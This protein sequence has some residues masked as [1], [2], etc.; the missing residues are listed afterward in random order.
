MRKY[1]FASITV[2]LYIVGLLI[3][4]PR[5]EISYAATGA[6]GVCTGNPGTQGNCDA[7][8]ICTAP[9]LNDP[10]VEDS[11]VK[12]HGKAIECQNTCKLPGPGEACTGQCGTGEV[13]QVNN[14]QQCTQ[15]Q[16]DGDKQPAIQAACGKVCKLEGASGAA[17]GGAADGPCSSGLVC[18]ANKCTKPVG[19]GQSCETQVN[20]NAQ[21]NCAS[22]LTC[23]FPGLNSSVP[24]YNP[25]ECAHLGVDCGGGTQQGNTIGGGTCVN[26]NAKA[27]SNPTE[28]PPP[29][30]PPCKQ[31]TA[32]GVCETFN[33][34]FGGF[35]TTPSTFIQN[36]F[37]ILLSV[38]GGIALLL[39]MRAGYSLM[40]AQGNPEKLGAG[41]EQL[42]AAIVGL[43]FLIFSFVFL[44]LIGFDIL[45]IP[46]FGGAGAGAGGASAASCAASGEQY[47]PTI[48]SCYPQSSTCP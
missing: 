48:K 39:I 46:G 47:C 20:G 9:D 25:E 14:Q 13:C 33:S 37:A 29:P 40:T 43:I 31:W 22:G 3:L 30:S 11:C 26:P 18:Y 12:T 32:Q 2:F 1:F 7:G 4:L 28:G 6:Q 35:S 24:G 10:A 34:A 17:C 27:A 42:I 15:T 21:G 45:H 8:L 19:T 23:K 36:I 41:R 38:S 5:Q 16:K 44:E